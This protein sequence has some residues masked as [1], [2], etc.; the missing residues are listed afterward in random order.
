VVSDAADVSYAA[1][2]ED[3]LSFLGNYGRILVV[4][5]ASHVREA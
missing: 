2:V 1:A 4:F 5:E 3:Y